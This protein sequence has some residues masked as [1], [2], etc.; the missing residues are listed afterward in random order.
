MVP[1]RES[2][3]TALPMTRATLVAA[4][5]TA[6]GVALDGNADGAPGDD[7]VFDFFTLPGDADRDGIVNFNDLLTLARNYNKSGVTLADGD[8]TGDGI[9]NFSDLL[10][11]ARNYNRSIAPAAPASAPA[12]ETAEMPSLA[13]VLAEL[14]APSAPAAPAAAPTTKAMATPKATP[15]APKVPPKLAPKPSK[16]PVL[17]KKDETVKRPHTPAGPKTFGSRRIVT[18]RH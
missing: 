14:A 3:R 2:S 1:T 12:D 9:V 16:P 13:S 6:G 18:A 5:I 10:I 15:P 8:F 17:V 7:Y 11:L 4:G